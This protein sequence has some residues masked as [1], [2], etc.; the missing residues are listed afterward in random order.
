MWL[1]IFAAKIPPCKYGG[2]MVRLRCPWPGMEGKPTTV[3][4]YEASEWRAENMSL[5]EFARKSNEAGEII[6][7]VKDL[8]KEHQKAGGQQSLAD[9][10]NMC[11]MKGQKLIACDMLSLFND[12]W[13]GQWLAL[14]KPFRQLE[15]LLDPEVVD[16]ATGKDGCITTTNSKTDKGEPRVN[17]RVYLS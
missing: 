13:F 8:Y 7:W 1:Y 11:P 3:E 15:E 4:N 12:R 10:A 9:F 2:T 17:K 16:K 6:Y 5:L 14:R